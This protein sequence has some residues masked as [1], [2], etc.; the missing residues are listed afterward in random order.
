LGYVFRGGHG[1]QVNNF[2]VISDSEDRHGDNYFSIR[3]R[4]TSLTYRKTWNVSQLFGLFVSTGAGSF[5][6]RAME[7]DHPNERGWSWHLGGGLEFTPEHVTS[8]RLEMGRM[9]VYL[10]SG[11]ADNYF[12]ALAAV[13]YI[14]GHPAAAGG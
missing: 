10:D 5:A 3:T 4:H 8:F 1:I 11:D 14:G 6:A 9:R 13:W 7:V 12:I 2:R